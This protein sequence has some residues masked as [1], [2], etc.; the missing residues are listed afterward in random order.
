M[1]TT[2]YNLILNYRFMNQF[3]FIIL[4]LG[5]RTICG[6]ESLTYALEWAL[7]CSRVHSNLCSILVL[8][9]AAFMDPSYPCR[10]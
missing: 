5:Y 6:V 1:T 4:R 2:I 8:T 9:Q 3:H 10:D 7:Q